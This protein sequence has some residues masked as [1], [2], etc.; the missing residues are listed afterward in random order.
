MGRKY[1]RDPYIGL[2][3]AQSQALARRDSTYTE[4]SGQSFTVAWN[5]HNREPKDLREAVRM[6]RQA[7]ADEVPTRLHEGY[8]SIGEGGT[9]KMDVRAEGYIFGRDDAGEAPRGKC[10]CWVAK[11]QEDIGSLD[12]VRS[13]HV[14]DC[15]ANHPALDYYRTPF[16]AALHHLGKT[17]RGYIVK[18]VALGS[19]GPQEAAVKEGVP[20]EF[21]KVV[22]W[23]VLCGFLRSLSDVKVS[24]AKST[25]AA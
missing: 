4:A 12:A 8:D 10:A 9:P 13:V 16:R 5:Y 11:E 23:D 15:P 14:R 24:I 7:Y 21:A 6:V 1:N 18:H 25:P 19:M 3:E 22:A 2:S 20:Y 17:K